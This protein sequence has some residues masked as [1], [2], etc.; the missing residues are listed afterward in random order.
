MG[1]SVARWM[2]LS[3]WMAGWM[4]GWIGTGWGVGRVNGLEGEELVD[5]G[6]DEWV[7]G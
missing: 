1:W 5:V 6:I 4:D 2:G 3:D 7:R